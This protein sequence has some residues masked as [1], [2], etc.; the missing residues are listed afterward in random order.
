MVR[1]VIASQY[2]PFSILQKLSPY[3]A[4]SA[5]IVVH[6]PYVQV[7][8]LSCSVTELLTPISQIVTDL[9]NQ[10]RDLPQYLGPTVTEMWLRKYQVLPGRTHPTMNMSGSGGFILHTIR[11]YA[12]IA[13]RVYHYLDAHM[14]DMTIPRRGQSWRIGKRRRQSWT[15][16]LQAVRGRILS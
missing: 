4:G 7:R 5:N 2:D 10:L 16:T 6:S 13:C 11:V 8:R 14:P 12:L 1:L 9:Q 15:W 3:L